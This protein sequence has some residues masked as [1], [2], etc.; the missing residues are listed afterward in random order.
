MAKSRA[1][2]VTESALS[3]PLTPI[4]FGILLI[5][6]CLESDMESN[7]HNT[8]MILFSFCDIKTESESEDIKICDYFSR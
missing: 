1:D 3:F 5:R 8:L 2:L 6:I 4:W 7:L